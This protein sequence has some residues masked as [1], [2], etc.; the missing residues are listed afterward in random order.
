MLPVSGAVSLPVSGPCVC[1]PGSIPRPTRQGS[2][3]ASA[4]KPKGSQPAL[5]GGSS[6]G[7]PARAR[8]VLE[9]AVT[10]GG[11]M[12]TCN[13][14]AAS[15]SVRLPARSKPAHSSAH[16]TMQCNGTAGMRSGHKWDKHATAVLTGR[17]A[18]KA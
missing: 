9:G 8:H 6:A 3:R 16:R 14:K 7:T 1:Y 5:G 13:A 12:V 4:G 11:L 18:S 17:S 10:Q 2:C 15:R